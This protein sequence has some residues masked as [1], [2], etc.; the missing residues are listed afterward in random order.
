[1]GRGEGVRIGAVAGEEG[2][3]GKGL[4]R[5]GTR[6]RGGEEG[7]A[8]RVEVWDRKRK[9]KGCGWRV[10]WGNWGVVGGIELAG[11]SGLWIGVMVLRGK[12][13]W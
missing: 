6:V 5:L 13:E 1:V 2:V 4:G 11:V 9:G 7:D 3:G 12:G 10:G 8:G